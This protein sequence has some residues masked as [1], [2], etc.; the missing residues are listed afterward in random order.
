MSKFTFRGSRCMLTF[1]DH[2]D[3]QKIV[4]AFAKLS[5]KNNPAKLKVLHETGKT[6]YEHTHVVVLFAKRAKITSQKKWR[7][8]RESLGQFDLKMVSTDEHFTN[9]LAYETSSKKK[10]T[11]E[12]SKV[13][14]DDIGEW[15]PEESYH[16]QVIDFLQH[17]TSWASV[18]TDP[19]HS[20]Y[21]CARMN[22]AREVYTHARSIVDFQF[23][24]GN[25]YAWQQ[26]FID[27]LKNPADNRTIHWV[28][29]RKGG[30]GKSDLTN[31]LMSHAN[32]FLVDQG[33]SADIAFA[34]DNQDVVIF[35]L[36][37]DCEDYCPY[38]SMEAFK[39]GRFFSPKYNSCVKR[40]TPPH[41]VVFANFCPDM[42][43]LSEDRWDIMALDDLELSSLPSTSQ[44]RKRA[45]GCPLSIKTPPG[46]KG[47]SPCSTGPVSVDLPPVSQQRLLEHDAVLEAREEPKE[48]PRQEPQES[49]PPHRTDRC[50]QSRHALQAC[51]Q[52]NQHVSREADPADRPEGRSCL[53]R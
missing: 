29:D 51:R 32:A 23:P 45:N 25:P 43:K 24:S 53:P 36:A 50:V 22:W 6:G 10:K 47:E 41:V 31:Y 19:E 49:S 27:F 12:N 48:A 30:N 5:P 38:R 9:C 11:S 34:Y 4:E 20:Q 52:E 44:Q 3:P 35:D 7:N 1:K 2:I 14:H 40:F 18:L 33:K 17:A 8:F 39:N 16:N 15:E 46:Q 21:I 42:T 28:N 13:V 26:V 37:R